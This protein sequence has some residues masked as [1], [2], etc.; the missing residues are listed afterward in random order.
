MRLLSRDQVAAEVEPAQ[1]TVHKSLAATAVNLAGA[2]N[3]RRLR[4]ATWLHGRQFGCSMVAAAHSS[5]ASHCEDA[6][7][8]CPQCYRCF[9]TAFAQHEVLRAEVVGDWLNETRMV[10]KTS[11]AA[12]VGWG[13]RWS[14]SAATSR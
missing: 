7:A 4:A 9:S 3:W 13:R 11:T 12:E 5:G 2:V 10:M 8:T 1:H 6:G 14:C